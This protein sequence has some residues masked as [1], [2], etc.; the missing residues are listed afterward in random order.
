MT[1]LKHST[2]C[3]PLSHTLRQNMLQFHPVAQRSP[4]GRGGMCK[5]KMLP[6]LTPV[7]IPT[8][9]YIQDNAQGWETSISSA[10]YSIWQAWQL[11]MRNLHITR[12]QN[13]TAQRRWGHV[14]GQSLPWQRWLKPVCFLH[15]LL[16]LA[17]RITAR[18]EWHQK[19]S[20]GEFPPCPR[21]DL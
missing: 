9:A 11:N 21:R 16:G 19:T 2:V 15:V 8:T 14:T 7:V 6:L 17:A 12:V 3:S 10:G 1:A 18:S 5:E 4:E 20:A 13:V